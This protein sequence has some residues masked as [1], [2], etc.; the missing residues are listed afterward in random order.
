[1]LILV[2]YS[3]DIFFYLNTLTLS[4]KLLDKPNPNIKIQFECLTFLLIYF[5]PQI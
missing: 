5:Q 4:F 1:M 3:L 2:F